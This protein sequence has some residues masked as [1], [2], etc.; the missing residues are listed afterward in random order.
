MNEV[1][2]GL[3]GVSLGIIFGVPLAFFI[4]WL[5]SLYDPLWDWYIGNPKR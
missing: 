5:I 2:P 4:I 3:I 1:L